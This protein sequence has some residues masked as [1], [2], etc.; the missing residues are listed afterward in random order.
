MSIN[1]IIIIIIIT[2]T[3]T[4]IMITRLLITVFVSCLRNIIFSTIFF[5]LLSSLCHNLRFI[6]LAASLQLLNCI[7]CDAAY[8]QCLQMSN[9]MLDGLNGNLLDGTG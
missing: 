7:D 1:I 5:R 3:T 2:T 6:L 8:C 4:I 9:K